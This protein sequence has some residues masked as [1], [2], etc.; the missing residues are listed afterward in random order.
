MNMTKT[1]YVTAVYLRLS[2]D[3][4]TEAE[5]N[6]IKS[7]RDIIYNY[8][9]QHEDL[10]YGKEYIDDGFS[11]VTIEHRPELNRLLEDMKRGKFS[12]VIC[13]DMSRLSRN[14]L[15][16]GNLLENV[17]QEYAIRFIAIGDNYDS[18][19][20]TSADDLIVP[21]R[22]LFNAQYS[23][24]ISKKVK[25]SFTAMQKKG[26]FTGAFCSYGYIKDPGDKH[27]LT[28]D[29]EAATVVRRVFELYNSGQGKI[30]IA[31]I[32]NNEG[33]PCPSEYKKL[34]GLNYRNAKRLNHTSYWTYSTVNAILNNEMYI[35]NMVLNKSERKKVR[36]RATKLPKDKWIVVKGTHE[37]I[38]DEA[39]WNITQELLKKRTR[40]MKFSNDNAGLFSGFIK[41]GDCKR[42]MAKISNRGEIS[43]VC[44]SYK[45]YST[46]ICSRHGVKEAL[47]E[48]LVLDKLNEQIAK[49]DKIVVKERSVR[50]TNVDLQGYQIRLD[51]L[52]FLKKSIYEDYKAGDLS[53]ED[54]LA[55][56]ADY[57][58]EEGMIKSQMNTLNQS[59]SKA[60]EKNE[61]IEHLKQF[62]EIKKLDR[63]TLA[64]ILD[65]IEVYEKQD[66]LNIDIRLK[67]SA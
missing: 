36:G 7:Q 63:A 20:V 46:K 35:G 3:D 34:K 45:R 14:Y 24:D 58:R 18:L 15:D 21:M 51:K 31:S 42:A 47:L 28:V 55:Y 13:K 57:E 33:I 52:Y 27:K 2:N 54:Y 38:I 56:K 19:Y 44:G 41:C 37:P 39:T 66:K 67:Y 29:V 65:S 30:S 16:A 11:G 60:G 59:I 48:K 23:K 9:S 26:D 25:A 64:C 61:W 5:S 6:S 32:L 49:M 8:I 12:A 50:S 53:K 17:F 4:G 1:K 22:S 43:Y 40:Q 10:V 62:K